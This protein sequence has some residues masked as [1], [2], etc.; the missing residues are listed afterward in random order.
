VST[1]PIVYLGTPVDSVRPLVALHEAGFDVR[2]VV[3]RPDARRGRGRATSASPVKAAAVDLGLPVAH[4]LDAVIDSGATRG[5][6]V[7]Y[8]RI[9]PADLLAQVPMLNLHF[10]KLPRWR[11]AAPVERAIL[12]GDTETAVAVMQMEPDLDT[13]PILAE[14][15]VSI[16]PTATAESLRA[17]LVE[18]G[19]TLL[20]AVLDDAVDVAP[21][22]Q[23]GTPLYAPK[24]TTADRRIDFTESIVMADRRI[25]IGR[26]WTTL[27]GER[28]IIW[29]ARSTD[30]ASLGPAGTLR[31]D[32]ERVL[33]D[34]VDG[35]LELLAVQP[36]GKS[37][38]DARAWWRGAQPADALRLGSSDG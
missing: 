18:I 17:Q 5:V 33:V 34:G 2:L 35:V 19:T 11:G 9:I 6:V 3:T 22:P 30:G 24:I 29:E 37:R 20:V 27:V 31:N 36:A 10:S 15:I 28:F 26:A 8:G 7:A 38:M 13:G 23:Q 16:G 21:R 14:E 4:D 25:R 32:G 1:D 12:A